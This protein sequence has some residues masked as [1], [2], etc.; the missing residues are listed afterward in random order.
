[1]EPELYYNTYS[2]RVK[3]CNY[4]TKFE[5]V[6]S[7]SKHLSTPRR[8]HWVIKLVGNIK[9]SSI[10]EFVYLK[11]D[12]ISECIVEQFNTLVL[13]N[14]NH[15]RLK[16]LVYLTVKVC[17]IGILTLKFCLVCIHILMDDYMPLTIFIS[18]LLYNLCKVLE[19][20]NQF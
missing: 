18:A 20:I 8:P 6:I 9:A 7:G 12:I 3:Y 13:C 2:K 10:L 11:I 15:L 4:N 5:Q 17:N 14:V 19:N 16:C 1:M